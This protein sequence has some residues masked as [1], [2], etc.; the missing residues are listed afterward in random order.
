MSLTSEFAINTDRCAYSSEGQHNWELPVNNMINGK[1]GVHS[2]RKDNT[3]RWFGHFKKDYVRSNKKI[4]SY[5]LEDV[6]QR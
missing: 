6:K 5:K 1:P 4:T 2:D 3:S